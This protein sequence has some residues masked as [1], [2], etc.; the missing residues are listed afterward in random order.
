MHLSPTEMDRLTIFTAASFA[1]EALARGLRLSAPEAIAVIA[2]DVNWAARSGASYEETVQAGMRAVKADQ[3]LDG[4]PVLLAE[5]RVEP[6]FDEGTRMVTIRHPLGKHE[7]G[8]GAVIVADEPL[9]ARERPRKQLEVHNTSLRVVRVSSHY[10][11]H[12]VNRRLSFDRESAT[13]WRLDLPAGR[14][15]RWGPDEARTVD[16]VPADANMEA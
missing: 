3:V 15:I 7:G 2:D 6:L 8:P 5:V 12:L 16:I 13:G 1:R 14:Y 11:L 4:V 9:P 10:P